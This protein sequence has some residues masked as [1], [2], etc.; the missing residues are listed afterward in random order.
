MNQARTATLLSAAIAMTVVLGATGASATWPIVLTAVLL[1]TV[2][3]G[4]IVEQQVASARQAQRG[5]IG[6]PKL[7]VQ[8]IVDDLAGK[9]GITPPRTFLI[10]SDVANAFT[11]GRSRPGAITVSSELLA[12]LSEREINGVL[13]HE[14]VHIVRRDAQ[15]LTWTAL[16]C[17]LIAGTVS[18]GA[19]MVWAAPYETLITFPAMIV[20]ACAAALT[21]MAICRSREFSADRHGAALCGDPLW[22]AA[23]LE[24]IESRDLAKATRAPR[25]WALETFRFGP[26][27]EQV[28][29]LLSTHPPSGAR[30]FRLRRLAGL[31]EP[32]D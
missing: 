10:D 7:A 17:G 8:S 20:G 13:A 14:I 5:F 3:M 2:G 24:R 22:I 21:Q 4:F 12:T 28:F 16:I 11:S 32:W 27:R 19:V 9:A 25:T 15:R 23:A 18:A 6:Q 29:G 30:I 31:S 26:R 1:G